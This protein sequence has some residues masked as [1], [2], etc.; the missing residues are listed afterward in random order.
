[1]SP[2]TRSLRGWLATIGLVQ[3]AELLEANRVDLDILPALTERDLQELGIP[4]GDRKRLLKAVAD[5]HAA[6]ATAGD[7]RGTPSL[8]SKGTPAPRA[9]QAADGERRQLT[10]LFCDLVDSTVLARRLDPEEYR[11]LVRGYQTACADV[12]QRLDGHVAQYLGDGLLVYFGYPEA[13]EDDAA[14]A[15]RVG[16]EIVTVIG[17]LNERPG[18][19]VALAVR[20]GIHTGLVVVGA[21]GGGAHREKLALGDTPN[22]AARLQGLAEPNT[23]VVS[24]ETRRLVDG[25]FELQILGAQPLKGVDGPVDVYRVLTERRERSRLDARASLTA[26]VGREP[27][28]GVLLDRWERAAEGHGHVVVVMGEPGIGKSRLVR[29][30]R[31]RLGQTPHRWLE[32]RCSP[33]F[34]NTPLYPFAELL[35]RVWGWTREAAPED[36]LRSLEMQILA[37]GIEPAEAVPL[38]A[39]LLA[40][41]APAHYPLPPMSPE[42]QRRRTLETVVAV[43]LAMARERPLLLAV[44]DLHWVDP[45]TLELL[46]QLI[47]QAPTAG[48]L[49]L[50]TARPEFAM[51]WGVRSYL[52]P[53]VLTR[54]SRRQTE[55]VLDHLAGGR[56]LAEDVT[57]EIV[58]KTDGVPLF[59]EELTKTVLESGILEWAADR[60]ELRRA[61]GPLSIPATL[62]DS[63]M[64]RLDRMGGA[65]EVAQ[66]GAALGRAFRYSWLRA[67]S[68]L[69][70][71][72]LLGALAQLVQGEL[73]FQRGVPPDPTYT[74]KHALIQDAA[75]Q[76]LLKRTRQRY[77]ARIAEVLVDQFPEIAEA[78]PELVAHHLTEAGKTELAVEYWT[79]AG[80]RA[81]QRSANQEATEHLRTGLGLLDRLPPS[82][83]RDSLELRLQLALGWTLTLTR[84]WGDPDTGLVFTRAAELCQRAGSPQDQASAYIGIGSFHSMRGEV[85]AACE[86][87]EKGLELAERTGDLEVILPL[88]HAV[89]NARFFRGDLIAARS[90]NER[91][92]ADYVQDKHARLTLIHGWDPKM[93]ALSFLAYALVLLGYPDQGLARAHECLDAATA[94]GVP[95]NH[96]WAIFINAAI[97]EFRREPSFACEHAERTLVVAREQGFP[98]WVAL[99]T[100]ELG[101]ALVEEGRAFAAIPILEQAIAAMNTIGNRSALSL[102]LTSLARACMDLGRIATARE[103]IAAVEPLHE[104]GQRFVEAEVLRARARLCLLEDP[105]DEPGAERWLLEAI[106]VATRQEAKWLEL[107]A[108]RDLARLWQRQGKRAEARALL[109]PVYVWFT[110]GFDTVD[111]MEAAALLGELG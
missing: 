8:T 28:V 33:Y 23:V 17:R 2:D 10:V 61:L 52:T 80:R 59:I 48:L 84:G 51:P 47:D 75:Y 62:R 4:L 41:P 100:A 103:A 56:A 58:A 111:L 64:A 5:R 87:F 77:H 86:L 85:D 7:E 95:S 67:A 57:Q 1:M 29:T 68:E 101:S 69:D 76:S 109:E 82:P 30:L 81:F 73:L 108:A 91:C 106:R 43:L 21:V 78:Q 18:A 53:L 27:E 55:Q 9:G 110:E 74:F 50:L 36:E 88:R 79:R 98:F 94:L 37:L 60:Y 90:W 38:L 15:V 97:R 96:V 49:L 32:A 20:V 66:L 22:I 42:R 19:H 92:L 16:L 54:L 46:G 25:L 65:K 93:A 35:P 83:G 14:R 89:G 63:L 34:A 6:A 26:L 105:R 24:G 45:T 13:H 104:A 102:H 44:E 107:R 40:R 31:E 99:A 12:V 72:A 3:Y 11:E 39:A 70:E 71:P